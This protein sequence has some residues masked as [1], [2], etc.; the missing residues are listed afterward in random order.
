MNQRKQKAKNNLR[1]SFFLLF[2]IFLNK[3]FFF[4]ISITMILTAF[5]LYLF[6]FLVSL[7]YGV[8]KRKKKPMWKFLFLFSCRRCWCKRNDRSFNDESH[9]VPKKYVQKNLFPRWNKRLPSYSFFCLDLSNIWQLKLK[10]MIIRYKSTLGLQFDLTP[11]VKFTDGLYLIYWNI[12]I[13]CCSG[14]GGSTSFNSTLW[15][16]CYCRKKWQN[17]LHRGI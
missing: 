11:L 17:N 4:P 8:Y 1:G 9:R 3:C 12:P 2:C 6:C 7:N 13:A 16:K 14:D 10:L 15:W 5:F